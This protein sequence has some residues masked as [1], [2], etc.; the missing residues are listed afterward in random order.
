MRKNFSTS[1]ALL[2]LGFAL[3]ACSGDPAGSDRTA[4]A[5]ATTAAVAPSLP[6]ATLTNDEAPP[7]AQPTGSAP[8]AA[9]TPEPGS[10]APT[11]TTPPPVTTPPVVV[12]DGAGPKPAASCTVTKDKDGFFTRT[13]ALSDY[14]AYVPA[15]YDGTKPLPLVVGLHGCGDNAYNFATWGPNPLAT[16]STQPHIGI[17][18][19]GETGNNHCW[20]MG[21]DDAKVLAAIDDIA[22]C[23]WVHQKEITIAGY[24]S[25]GQLAY[26]VGMSNASRFAG[27]LI[28]NSG[29]YAASTDPTSLLVNASR[30]IPVAHR[31]HQSDSVFPLA[32]VQAD[33]AAMQSR[34]FSVTTS[35]VAG[36]HSGT[37][38]DWAEWLLPQA[39][40]WKAP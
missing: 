28:E 9:T 19:G 3:V 8:P 22:S 10:P 18:V 36:D 34:G 7:A 14:V 26:R 29:L 11:A 40:A 6:T 20:S 35:V 2:G 32:K 30:K 37:S 21:A 31:A 23:F 5:L 39:Q 25:G 13:S 12:D 16:R 38:A 17:S 24:S 1:L 33:W 15:S 27:I 4:P